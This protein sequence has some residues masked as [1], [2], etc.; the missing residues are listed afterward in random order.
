MFNIA[1]KQQSIRSG[2]VVDSESGRPI[3]GVSVEIYMK[4]Q[5]KDSLQT[6]VVTD[7]N[8]LFTTGEKR[9]ANQMFILEKGGYISYVSSLPKKG[10]TIRMEKIENY[11]KQ[12]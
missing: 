2:I 11:Y 5:V 7:D 6:K 9:P 12:Q 10:D 4:D 3:P 8:G 1:C